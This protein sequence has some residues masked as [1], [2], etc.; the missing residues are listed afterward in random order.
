LQQTVFDRDQA[1][2]LVQLAFWKLGETQCQ[3]S[4]SVVVQKTTHWVD[5]HE[6]Q[7]RFFQEVEDVE[8]KIFCI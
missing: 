5:S 7:I 8:N 1:R 3:S 4:S 2:Q 6:R